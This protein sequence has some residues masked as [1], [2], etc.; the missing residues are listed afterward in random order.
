MD[1]RPMFAETAPKPFDS[2]AYI[3]EP[4]W[5]GYRALF[6]TQEKRLISRTGKSL[7]GFFPHLEAVELN[8]S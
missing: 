1:Y 6:Y 5:D 2:L 3:F 4:K 7:S 8:L